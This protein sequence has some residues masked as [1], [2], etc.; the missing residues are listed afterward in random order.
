MISTTD[1]RRKGFASLPLFSLF[2]LIV[3]F[4]L[5]AQ[6]IDASVDTATIK[7]GEQITYSITVEAQKEDLV[8]FPEGQTFS[9]LEMIESYSVD[10]TR[11]ED[12]L[13]LLKEYAITQFDSGSY[14]IPRQRVMINDRNFFTDSMLVEVRD[15]EVDTTKQHLYPIKPSVEVPGGFGLPLWA[16]ILLGILTLAALIYFFFRRKK[17]K[18][19]A[20]K[21]LPPY[22]QAIFELKQLDSSHLLEQREIKQYYS[23]LSAAV[24]RYLDGEV[25]DHAMESTSGEL[26]AYLE[27]EKEAGRLH[28]K[29]ETITRLKQTLERADLAKFANTKPDVITAREDRSNVELVIND[30]KAAIP[31]P[32]EEELLKDRE[33]RERQLRKKRVRKIAFGLIGVIIIL[34]GFTAYVISTSGFADFKDTYLGHPSKELLEGD[35][36]RSD[37]GKPPV[38]ISTPRVL[39]RVTPTAPE[40]A[41]VFNEGQVFSSGALTGTYYVEVSARQVSSGEF[42]PSGIIDNVLDQLEEVGARNIITKE[43]TFTTV[44]GAEGLKIFGNLDFQHPEKERNLRKKYTF[45]SFSENV[46]IQQIMIVYDEE[47]R[48]AEEITGRLLNSI[49]FNAE[50]NVR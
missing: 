48:Y 42:D 7:I 6:Q 25:F 40:T 4:S 10:T 5:N 34:A 35:W 23:Q 18:E 12:R 21:K 43:E 19:E 45:L 26:V 2:F 32:T 27:A 3:S 31:Q 37:Y 9:P 11:L 50:T 29:E 24:R 17:K 33:Y 39:K 20:V 28:L 15:V 44:N 1:I 14:T 22:E 38:V 36:I 16:W 49:E 46:G 13:K 47:D 41:S 30:T 8:V